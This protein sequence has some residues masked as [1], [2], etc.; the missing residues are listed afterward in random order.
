[1]IDFKS[2]NVSESIEDVSWNLVRNALMDSTQT[3]C[4]YNTYGFFINTLGADVLILFI[5]LNF[6]MDQ[7]FDEMA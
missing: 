1:M 3:D 2:C 7:I 5:D 6:I 4:Y